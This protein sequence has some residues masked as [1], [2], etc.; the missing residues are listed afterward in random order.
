MII[1]KSIGNYLQVAEKIRKKTA[2]EFQQQADGK[3]DVTLDGIIVYDG[4]LLADFVDENSLPFASDTAFKD[5]VYNNSAELGAGTTITT[6]GGGGGLTNAEIRATP[7]DVTATNLATIESRLTNVEF[8]TS[9]SN[10][11]ESLI[12][13]EIQNVV[14]ELEPSASATVGSVSVTTVTTTLLNANASRNG[15]KLFN[16]SN[17]TVYVKF[18]SGASTTD[19]SF[20]LGHLQLYENDDYTGIITACTSSSTATI[21]TSEL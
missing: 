6:T 21:K 15:F 5:F 9:L 12:R 10:T 18:G 2:W 7:L 19:Y 3:W 8:A 11:N 20:Q 14:A 4:K 13:G 17:R 16:E 1:V